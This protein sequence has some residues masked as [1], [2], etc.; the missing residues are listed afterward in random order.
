MKC[1]LTT[2]KN[3]NAMR[4]QS[5]GLVEGTP[6]REIKQ[7]DFLMWNFGSVYTVNK[8]LSQTSKTL[9]IST[10]PINKTEVYKQRFNKDRLVCILQA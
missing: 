6:A 3:P 7:G 2:D 1:K 8:I 4:L 9:T 5:I 10:S